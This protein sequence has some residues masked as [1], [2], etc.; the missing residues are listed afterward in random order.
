MKSYEGDQK[1]K[2]Q[3]TGLSKLINIGSCNL[4]VV[5]GALQ[6]A[7]ETTSW[8]LKSIIKEAYQVLKHSPVHQ[9]DYISITRFTVFPLPF[10]FTQWVNYTDQLVQ[11]GIMF[12]LLW[13]PY[14]EIVLPVSALW[15]Q[16]DILLTFTKNVL[17]LT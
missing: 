17:F 12:G 4:H 5:H 1:N 9:E 11:G 8:G 2:K 16:L 13:F 14:Q 3:Q 10:C 6:S 7:T 15:Y